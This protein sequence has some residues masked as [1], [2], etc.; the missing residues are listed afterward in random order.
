MNNNSNFSVALTLLCLT[1]L[2]S[3]GQAQEIPQIGR[4]GADMQGAGAPKPKP[5]FPKRVIQLGN[6]VHNVKTDV[7]SGKEFSSPFN[8]NITLM[9]GNGVP[10]KVWGF[11]TLTVLQVLD[12]QKRP[13]PYTKGRIG[14]QLSDPVSYGP[15]FDDGDTAHYYERDLYG[16]ET[17]GSLKDMGQ[18]ADDNGWTLN[19]VNMMNSHN[20]NNPD[21][22][23]LSMIQGFVIL[24]TENPRSRFRPDPAVRERFSEQHVGDKSY[25][26]LRL[27]QSHVLVYH[28]AYYTRSIGGV[29]VPR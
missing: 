10:Q 7:V 11:L 28:R 23:W 1:A 24:D 14:E 18:F 27:G 19:G 9:D 13:E 5:I 20:A 26:G 12:D 21:E 15:T 22:K 4:L 2:S 29:I 25:Q 17:V 16:M 6:Q 8:G 3:V